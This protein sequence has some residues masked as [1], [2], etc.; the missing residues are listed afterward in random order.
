[1]RVLPSEYNDYQFIPKLIQNAVSTAMK[2]ISHDY[3]SHFFRWKKYFDQ[4]FGKVTTS[5]IDAFASKYKCSDEER[6]D[7]LKEFKQRKGNLVKMT[8][9]VMLSEARDAQRWVEDYI[10]PAMETGEADPTYKTAMQKS[11]ETLQ[12]RVEKEDAAEAAEEEDYDFDDEETIS[13]DDEDDEPTPKKQKV[14]A[15][16]AVPSPKGKASSAKKAK[17]SPKGKPPKHAKKTKQDDM[18]DL[19]AQIRNKNRGGGNVLKDLSARYGVPS[20][21]DDDPLNDAEFA[22]IQAKLNKKRRK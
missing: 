5:D 10:L 7:V 11:L 19:V 15:K 18:S 8:E 21:D 14:S 3:C 17:P 12:A 1:V 20:E 4:I 6:R 9:F 2:P 13:E 16:K 22:K